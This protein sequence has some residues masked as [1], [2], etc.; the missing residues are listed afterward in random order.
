MGSGAPTPGYGNPAPGGAASRMGSGSP[1][2]P[3]PPAGAA[4]RMGSGGFSPGTAASGPGR[5]S[6]APVQQPSNAPRRGK[7]K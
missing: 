3:P 2:A 7:P 5:P 1:S 4:G 6:P